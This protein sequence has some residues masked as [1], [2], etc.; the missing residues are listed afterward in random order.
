M[1]SVEFLRLVGSV[2]N[3]GGIVMFNATGSSEVHRTA[4][5]A[6]PDAM[7][8]AN[9]MVGSRDRIE[10]DVERWEAVM[11]GYF[12]EGAPVLSDGES[13]RAASSH[14]IRNGSV[15]SINL[16]PAPTIG[17]A[18]RPASTSSRAPKACAW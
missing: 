6:F 9:L 18:S 11:E 1:L 10:I 13:A 2:L 14:A 5:V 15:P 8:F 12:I 16:V 4:A 7:R 3:P 17:T